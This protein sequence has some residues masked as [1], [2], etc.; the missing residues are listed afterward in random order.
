[1]TRFA[2]LL[3]TT[4][5][6]VSGPVLA[7]GM[8]EPLPETMVYTPAPKSVPPAPRL[9]FSVLGGVKAAP[10]YFG[11]DDYEFGP[12]LGFKLHFLNFGN[13]RSFGDPDPF[14]PGEGLSLR[15]SF[16][17][18]SEREDVGTLDDIDA[19]LEVGFGL[20]YEGENL[21]VFAD[22]R[23]GFGGHEGFVVEVGGDAIY[24][25]SDRMTLTL[26]PR[27]LFG[28][29]DYNQT[30]FGISTS[31]IGPDYKFYQPDGGL[32]SIGLEA[33]ME[34]R[35]TDKLALEGALRYDNLTGHAHPSDVIANGDNDQ[36]TV[37]FG[38]RRAF[39]F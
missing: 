4:G 38:I 23:R 39:S 26:G 37:K 17:Y 21:S 31:E 22:L 9:V 29:E 35:L 36:F 15:G 18:I 11:S 19:T 30:Y 2:I 32:V 10:E 6:L 1:M 3:A 5:A 14:A 16:R 33:G 8:L 27:V 12:S 24:R 28:D 34:Y 7:A 25:A 20:G 13:G